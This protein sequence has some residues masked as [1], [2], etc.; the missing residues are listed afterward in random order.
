MNASPIR[1]LASAAIAAAIALAGCDGGSGA[2]DRDT[3]LPT[4]VPDASV[5]D[6]GDAVDEPDDARPPADADDAGTDA[7]PDAIVP[8]AADAPDADDARESD[9][10]EDVA[11]D[12]PVG[13]PYRVS[14]SFDA[15]G[16]VEQV[17]VR[18][19][20]PGT[21]LQVVDVDGNVAHEAAVDEWG[22]LIF[23]NVAPGRGY[24][25]RPADDPDDYT[26]PLTVK[27]IAGSRPPDA[28]YESQVLEPGFGYLETR[29]GTLL[30]YFLTLPGPPEEGP[31]PTVVAY[32][33]YS[34]SRPG[35]VLSP[36]VE[37]FCGAYPTLC[38]APD[39]PSNMIAALL[40]FATIGVNMRGTGCS[41]GG[42]DYFEPLQTLDGYD[43]IEIVSRQPWVKHHQVGMVGIS[44]PGI[45]QLFVAAAQ[46]P[47]L[48]A[49]APQSVIAD[50]AT[51][52]LMPGGIYNDGFA[53]EWHDMVLYRARPYD[54]QWVKDVIAA[55]DTR[56]DAHQKM[57]GQQRDAIEEA[58]HYPYYTDDVAVPVDPSAWVDRIQVPVLMTGQWHD[59]QTGPH[60]AALMDRFTGSPMA[61]FTVTNGFHNDSASPQ[62]LVEWIEF[63]YLFVSREPPVVDEGIKG[64]ASFFMQEIFGAP[65]PF[66]DSD[67]EGAE[68]LDAALALWNARP[69]V[70]AIF[71]SGAQSGP[72]KPTPQ[73]LFE[74]RFDAWPIPGTIAD[75]WYLGPD[76]TMAAAAPGEDGGGSAFVHDPDAGQRTTITSGGVYRLPPNWNWRVPEAG[77]AV[78]FVTPPL[79]ADRVMLGHGSADLWIRTDATDVDLEVTISE[80]DPDGKETLVQ[81]GWLRASHRALRD[82]ATEL[83]PTHTHRFEDVAPLVPGE[84]TPVRVEIMPFGHVFHAGS[85]I[86]VMI[87]TPGDSTTRW[88]FRLLEHETP[89]TVEIGHDAT[90]PSS[91]ALPTI[92]GVEVPT[93]RPAC[94][95][96]RGQPCRDYVPAAN[97]G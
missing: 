31:Y 49:I 58:L 36:D 22:S 96:L 68:D 66:P 95:A 97:G 33:G 28:F 53:K 25:V 52:C 42:Y 74:Q 48:A 80:I 64:L 41:D 3:P 32:S 24:S 46:P 12:V 37:V 72:S 56:C 70:R 21:V 87:D 44:F 61:R 50:S 26:G 10:P 57:H 11:P 78:A 94:G 43:V 92:P 51:S 63:L 29:D 27:S 55:G 91:V 35:R 90:H 5:T 39:D 30:S 34:P 38:N 85:R 54:H 89:P 75:R 13:P 7:A 40:G 60:F 59:E 15:R 1:F 76:G 65:I 9:V 8:D 16:S 71:E 77:K 17:H 86:R 47:G 84:W 73:G 88:R 4:D 14:E 23:R 69:P 18:T 45:S 62:A 83:R 6:A 81:S 93:D 20:V 82:D 2:P 19:A 79:G 67:I